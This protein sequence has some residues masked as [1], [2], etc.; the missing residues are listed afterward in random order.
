MFLKWC[1]K[2]DSL[3]IFIVQLE[4]EEADAT[5]ESIKK[6]LGKTL[7]DVKE[8]ALALVEMKKRIQKSILEV[9]KGLKAEVAFPN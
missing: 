2:I 8:K 3:D 5:D 9:E 1:K 7:D 6:E 4:L